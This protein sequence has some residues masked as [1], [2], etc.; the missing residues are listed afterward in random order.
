MSTRLDAI[1]IQRFDDLY[2]STPSAT[3]LLGDALDQIV[4]G[5][6]RSAIEQAR[7][8]YTAHGEDAYKA[9]KNT[10]PQWTFGGTFTPRRA[11]EHLDQH[12]GIC[13]ADIDHLDDVRQHHAPPARRSACAV[14]L[15]LTSG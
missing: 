1:E 9:A 4:D 5:T 8:L 7:R 13:H 12:S 15:H 14:L 3:V 11:K 2:D 6:Y 10:L